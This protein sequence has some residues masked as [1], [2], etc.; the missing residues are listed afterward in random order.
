VDAYLAVASKRDE[1]DYADRPLPDEVV[2]RILEAGRHAGSARNRQPWRFLVV[3]EPALRERV[4]ELVWEP[5][6]VRRAAL[7]VA[8]AV[9]G[10]GTAAFDSG[11]AAQNMMI[12]AWNDGVSSCPNGARDADGMSALLPLDAEE[13]PLVVLTFG[14]PSR[15]RDPSRRAPEGWMA[16]LA[17]RPF[18]EVVRFL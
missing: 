4:A 14:Y 7:V 17:R 6:N 18:D 11:R 1:R 10:R 13:S 3:R 2:R 16:G 15:P 9:R 5:A 8:L 12:A